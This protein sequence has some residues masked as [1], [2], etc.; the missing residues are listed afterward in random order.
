[1]FYLF[2][3]L[4]V[5]GSFIDIYICLFVFFFGDMYRGLGLMGYMKLEVSCCL[6]WFVYLLFFY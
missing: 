2:R 6:N 1:M 3:V 5:V 4:E